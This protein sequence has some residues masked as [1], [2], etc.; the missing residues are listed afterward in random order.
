MICNAATHDLLLNW[1]SLPLGKLRTSPALPNVVVPVFLSYCAS[2]QLQS[3]GSAILTVSISPSTMKRE[4]A[5]AR[6]KQPT[7][8]LTEREGH[9]VLHDAR[10]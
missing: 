3:S 6:A 5:V 1:T 4:I 2:V 10:R 7:D 9:Q 8:D